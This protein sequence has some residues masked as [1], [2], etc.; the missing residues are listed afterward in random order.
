VRF[1]SRPESDVDER[2]EPLN[3][4]ERAWVAEHVA[5]AREALQ[6]LGL[7]G[8]GEVPAKSLDE[9]WARSLAE[10]GDP[11][12][13]INV[14][15]LALGQLLVTRFGLEWVALTDEYGTEVAVRGPSN[16]TV[17]PTNFV[18]K[19]YETAE[20]GFITPFVDEVARTLEQ[21]A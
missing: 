1:W 8:D 2:V 14:V 21:L 9:L 17:F 20:T 11:N 13:A 7:P 6:E 12:R 15:G 16:F 3:D 10:P 18:A 4:A 19:R 5:A